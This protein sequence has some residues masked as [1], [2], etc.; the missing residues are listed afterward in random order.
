MHASVSSSAFLVTEEQVSCSQRVTPLI[1]G[2]DV[3]TY[4]IT[5]CM[6]VFQP[7]LFQ[8]TEEQVSCSQRVTPL[9]LWFRC[10]NILHRGMQDSVSAPSV[11]LP[12]NRSVV[13][14]E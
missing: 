1:C 8:I 7:H 12:R 3:I 11:S 10:D 4:S 14:R 9:M 5:A 6:P 2:L 13:A